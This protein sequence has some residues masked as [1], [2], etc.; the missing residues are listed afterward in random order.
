MIINC[1]RHFFEQVCRTVAGFSLLNAG[2]IFPTIWSIVKIFSSLVAGSSTA[3]QCSHARSSWQIKNTKYFWVT[4]SKVHRLYCFSWIITSKLV[5]QGTI[6]C[7]VW[8]L[9]ILKML[10]RAPECDYFGPTHSQ[11]PVKCYYAFSLVKQKHALHFYSCKRSFTECVGEL[12]LNALLGPL[13]W[14]SQRSQ[15]NQCKR[16]VWSPAGSLQLQS[17]ES[18]WTKDN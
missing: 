12:T 1:S 11:K 13:K 5:F 2:F 14:K 8:Q 6:S 4:L 18:A 15:C 3:Q 7:Y 16:L 10:I 9:S 17:L